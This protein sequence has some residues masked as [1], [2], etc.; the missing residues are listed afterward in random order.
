VLPQS[1]NVEVAL[2][3]FG[4]RRTGKSHFASLTAV[5]LAG[6]MVL[7]LYQYF[8]GGP[9]PWILTRQTASRAIAATAE[10]QHRTK[11]KFEL[12]REEAV[13]PGAC[14]EFRFA[15][16]QEP[17]FQNALRS[18]IMQFSA[19]GDPN[20]P[21]PFGWISDPGSFDLATGEM[22]VDQV[23][24]CAKQVEVKGAGDYELTAGEDLRV[25]VSGIT[26]DGDKRIVEF[27]WYFSRLNPF[28]R[29]LPRIENQTRNQKNDGRITEHERLIAPSWRGVGTFARYDY[30]WRLESIDFTR[31]KDWNF[32]WEY[33]PSWPDPSFNWHTFDEGKNRF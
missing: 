18:G 22:L 33:G 7:F 3:Q 20:R 11:I 30:G 14:H 15:P 6:I 28:A 31:E 16:A 21:V 10:F 29:A 5:A 25:E 12:G 9:Q 13:F 4:D 32:H 8:L 23:G 27:R 19:W 17:D 24:Q 26:R 1:Y 2:P